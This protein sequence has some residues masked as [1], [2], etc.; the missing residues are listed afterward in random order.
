MDH[1]KLRRR[2]KHETHR[3]GKSEFDPARQISD[4]AG[5]LNLA[6]IGGAET[7]LA[8]R[9]MLFLVLGRFGAFSLHP[10]AVGHVCV[11]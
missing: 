4:E 8:L 2:G 9:T 7:R 11:A 6:H 10:G 3:T 5:A 1:V